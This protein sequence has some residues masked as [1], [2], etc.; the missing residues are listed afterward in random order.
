MTEPQIESTKERI[1]EE[2]DVMEDDIHVTNDEDAMTFY[3]PTDRLNQ[4]QEVLDTG[5][6]VL[7]EHEQEYLVKI[8]L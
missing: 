7:E 8:D 1:L 2:F 4:A 5:I 6:E 3:L